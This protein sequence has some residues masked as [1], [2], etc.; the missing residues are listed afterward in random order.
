MATILLVDD[1]RNFLDLETSFLRRTTSSLI[2]AN[3]GVEAIRIAREK[4]PDLIMLDIEMPE[5]NG[6]EACRILKSDPNTQ[7]IPII[8]V[9]T[10]AKRRDEC[11]KLG[12]NDFLVKPITEESFLGAITRLVPIRVRHLKRV[13]VSLPVTV[14]L[15]E[16]LEKHS[17]RAKDL[18]EKGLFLLMDTPLPLGTEGTFVFTLPDRGRTL[19]ETSGVVV[20]V[21]EPGNPH[22]LTS[23]VGVE[24]AGLT[25]KQRAAIAAFIEASTA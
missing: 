13:P 24:L 22:N 18:S 4:R 6:M 7:H 16:T 25:E 23:G 9:T 3:T 19:V 1:M 20:R 12:A 17:L 10:L 21:V 5:M 14:T 15:K 2:F 8:M 11:L